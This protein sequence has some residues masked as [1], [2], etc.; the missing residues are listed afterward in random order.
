[1]VDCLRE[2]V[3]PFKIQCCLII[4]DYYRT[5]IFAPTNIKF[6]PLRILDYTDFNKGYQGGVASLHN[7]Q[8]GD[9]KKATDIIVDIVRAEGKA[10]GMTLPARLPVGADAFEKMREKSFKVL[11]Q[12]DEWEEITSDTNL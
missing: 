5:N 10:V 11:K 3:S 2:E 1:M 12:C 9:P 6:G 8:P 4:P 7:N